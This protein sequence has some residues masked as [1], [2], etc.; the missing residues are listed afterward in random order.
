M[1]EEQRTEDEVL[2]EQIDDLD[3]PDAQRED[4]AG[5]HTGGS[6]GEDRLTENVTLN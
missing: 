6:S 5:G 4:V 1:A 2:D 3:V